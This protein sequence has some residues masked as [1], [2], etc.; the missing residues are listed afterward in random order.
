MRDVVLC[1]DQGNRS[2][3]SPLPRCPNPLSSLCQIPWDWSRSGAAAGRLSTPVSALLR[4]SCRA[5]C[6]APDTCPSCPAASAS[7]G[8]VAHPAPASSPAPDAVPDPTAA[9]DHTCHS[10]AAPCCHHDGSHTQAGGQPPTDH[11]PACGLCAKPRN[12][13]PLPS[14]RAD[15]GW[16]ESRAKGGNG[17]SHRGG[18]RWRTSPL[19]M[20]LFQHISRDGS[21]GGL[22]LASASPSVPD[23]SRQPPPRGL[24]QFSRT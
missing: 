8:L 22:L 4:S 1:K 17:P 14:P 21:L 9:A 7:T 3:L 23:K 18:R 6:R 15:Q 24:G 11:R 2:C 19:N 16:T 10:P 5:E 13:K 12:C 20:A